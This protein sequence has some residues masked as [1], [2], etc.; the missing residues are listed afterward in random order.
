MKKEKGSVLGGRADVRERRR[1]H[2][3]GY[4]FFNRVPVA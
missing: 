2:R 4:V 1:I 3:A